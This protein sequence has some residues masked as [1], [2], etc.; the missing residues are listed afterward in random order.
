MKCLKKIQI[1]KK[2]ILIKRDLLEKKENLKDKAYIIII[3]TSNLKI[4]KCA[5]INK[6][7]DIL[8]LKFLN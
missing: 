2:A 5:I 4:K 8:I 7:I 1:K 6:Y 3:F